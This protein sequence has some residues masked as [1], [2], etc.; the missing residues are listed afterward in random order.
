VRRPAF[1]NILIAGFALCSVVAYVMLTIGSLGHTT[2]DDAYMVTRYAKH[3]LTG[4]GFSW[5]IADGPSYGVTS[6]FYLIVITVVLGVTRCSDAVALTLTSY[7]AGLLSAVALVILGFMAEA[8]KRERSS[9][10]PLLVVPCLLLMPLFVTHSL[11]GMETTMSLLAN[12][13]L[14]CSI[15]LA[16]R[17]RTRSAFVQCA[18]SAFLSYTTRPD[19]GLYALFLPPLFFVATD[20]SLWKSALGHVTLVVVLVSCSLVVNRFAF[21]DVLPLPFFAKAGGFYEG[22]VG[23]QKWNAVKETL[24]FWS[25][26]TPFLL[27]I[28]AT[29]SRAALP[30]LISVMLVVTATFSYYAT[31]A[32]IMAS[33]ARYYY[34][35]LAFVVLAAFSTAASQPG[36]DRRP[37]ASDAT[38]ARLLVGLLALLPVI[39]GPLRTVATDLWA[40]HVIGE[41]SAVRGVTR[42]QTRA[43]GA[44]PEL[45]WWESIKSMHRLLERMPQGTVVAASEYGFLGSRLPALTIIDLVGLHDRTIAHHGFDVDYVL[46]REPDVVWFPHADYSA[47]VAAILDHPGFRR[48]YEYYPGAYDYGVALRTSA[49]ASAS[50]R[51]VFCEEFQ[52]TY[53]GLDP[54]DSMAEAL[55]PPDKE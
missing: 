18:F 54:V 35:S 9:W 38:N 47:A 5:N 3:W 36:K 42:Y 15:L 14:A 6:S 2:F 33:S 46:S 16:A 50:I 29:A 40:K 26:A 17:R 22:Y 20:R 11:T 27:L 13:V 10:M 51:A 8:G 31:V 49:D 45:G 30:Q 1:L 21:G 43:A 25:A 53:P 34:P 44:P 39:S 12:S 7:I 37:G 24:L 52:R 28:V 4:G 55:A 19:N 41:P 32:Q 23:A 48:D